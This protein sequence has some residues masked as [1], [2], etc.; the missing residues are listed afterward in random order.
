VFQL[1]N[2]SFFIIAPPFWLA[3]SQQHYSEKNKVAFSSWS[4]ASSTKWL[5]QVLPWCCNLQ[6]LSLK[7]LSSLY[8]C[9]C[10]FLLF[11]PLPP[12][13]AIVRPAFLPATPWFGPPVADLRVSGNR[14]PIRRFTH[15]FLDELSRF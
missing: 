7:L 12:S 3:I 2:M 6:R 5:V 4:L 9:Q 10:F 13:A 15:S 8:F 14:F 11:R 1:R